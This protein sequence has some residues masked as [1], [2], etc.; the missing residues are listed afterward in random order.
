MTYSN[1]KLSTYKN[2][3]YKNAFDKN[4]SVRDRLIQEKLILIILLES[5]T[6]GF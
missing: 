4:L 2:I 6:F 3:G 1:N 5:Y